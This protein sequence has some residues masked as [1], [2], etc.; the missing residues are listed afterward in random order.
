M[1]AIAGVLL[2]A[3][4]TA[5][6]IKRKGIK[7]HVS[8]WRATGLL[9]D[10]QEASEKGN[11]RESER[12]ALAA[13]QLNQGNYE[14]LIQLYRSALKQ[15][16]QY[17]LAT[18]RMV[19]KHPESN[20]NDRIEALNIF[21]QV[22]DLVTFK[23]L[24]SELP[25]EEQDFPEAMALGV[26]YLMARSDFPRAL[27]LVEEL[28]RMRGNDSDKLFKARILARIE[29]GNK[30]MT[31]ETQRLIVELF[32]SD[33]DL[34]IALSA[35]SILKQ[36]PKGDWQLERFVDANDRLVAIEKTREV[37]VQLWLLAFEIEL[38]FS[39][40]GQKTIVD[41]AISDWQDSEPAPLCSWLLSL[42]EADRV[43]SLISLERARA[44]ESLFRLLVQANIALN[45]WATA[46]KLLDQPHPKMRFSI[47]YGLKAAIKSQQGE[48]AESDV[49]WSRALNQAE[50]STGQST[51]LDLAKLA[52]KSGNSDIRNRAMTEA[53]RRPSAVNLPVS[54]VSFLFSDLASENESENLLT[55]SRNLLMTD[56]QNPVLINNVVWLELITQSSRKNLAKVMESLVAKHPKMN[57][58]RS[59]L[60]LAFIQEGKVKDA[61]PVLGPIINEVSKGQASGSSDQAVV[62]LALAKNGDRLRAKA[63]F[64]GIDWSQMMEIERQFFQKQ[65][66]A[67][68]EP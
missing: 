35:F 31:D 67:T 19:F 40:S 42:G 57:E 15:K 44:S 38:A 7:Y 52:S 49:L 18:A 3:F 8:S 13:W 50:L 11:W 61:V 47:V 17:L 9:G 32:H 54:E 10:A 28:L 36:I 30:S 53:L 2:I 43:I 4:S 27:T 37:P 39:P 26:K 51:L 5:A 34:S 20:F 22:G 68:L 46:Q 66:S 59:T 14:V 23:S 48:H 6:F 41:Q 55:V 16:S 64:Q 63:L 56:P 25:N 1:A 62:A 24:F 58:L 45:D 60:A 33:S 29:S 12:L 65:I 21:L